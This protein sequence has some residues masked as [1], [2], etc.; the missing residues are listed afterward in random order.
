MTRLRL[1]LVVGFVLM[2]AGAAAT[3]EVVPPELRGFSIHQSDA[4]AGLVPARPRADD[5]WVKTIDGHAYW[6]FAAPLLKNEVD[7]VKVVR[8]WDGRWGVQIHLTQKGALQA[9]AFTERLVGKKIAFVIDGQMIGPEVTIEMQ[10]PG[11]VW[12]IPAEDELG[13]TFLAY[14]F[15]MVISRERGVATGS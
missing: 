6:L 14:R 1:G 5:L 2:T 11:Q 9:A 3:A 13:A 12:E 10:I 8:F 4:E 7:G 15:N